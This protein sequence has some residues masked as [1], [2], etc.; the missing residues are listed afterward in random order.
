VGRFLAGLDKRVL[1]LGSGG[2][3]HEPPV[4]LIA[5]APDEIR[6]FLI[7]GRNPTPE[8]RAARQAR[9][10]AAGK[11]Y[12]TAQSPLTPLNP[13]GSPDHRGAAARRSGRL[14]RFDIEEA[15]RLA[16]RSSRDPHLGGRLC[17][18]GGGGLCG[19]LR[20]LPPDRPVDRGLRHRQRP[21]SFRLKPL[22]KECN[23]WLRLLRWMRLSAPSP[24]KTRSL[25]APAR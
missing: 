7:A 10:L 2:L 16:G 20:L 9:T 22:I 11:V 12:G 17:R 15:S 18:A 1:I 24:P 19:H 21:S 13:V 5:A 3:S 23:P 4:P 14:R 6:Q 8:A 25:N